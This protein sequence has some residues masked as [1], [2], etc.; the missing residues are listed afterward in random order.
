[1]RHSTSVLLV[2][3]DRLAGKLD[4]ELRVRLRVVVCD[5]DGRV[6]QVVYRRVVQRVPRPLTRSL[7]WSAR[8]ALAEAVLAHDHTTSEDVLVAV[9]VGLRVLRLG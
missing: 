2:Q 7:V 6:S 3:T 1:M 4:Q 8:I 5:K 9:R